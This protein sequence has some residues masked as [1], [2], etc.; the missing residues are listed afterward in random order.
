MKRLIALA[1][2]AG[3]GKNTAADMLGGRQIAFAEPLKRFCQEVFAFTDEQVWGRSE[4]RNAPDKRYPRGDCP[5]CFGT[6]IGGPDQHCRECGGRGLEYLTPR[7]AL[8]TLG[9]EWGRGCFGNVWAELGVRRAL[10]FPEDLVV[11]TDCRFINE[12]KSVRA[13]GGEVWRIVR[14]GAGLDG[15]AGL[16]PS[17]AEQEST[18]FLALVGRT[19]VNSGTLDDLKRI[20]ITDHKDQ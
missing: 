2:R 1:G 6:G 20:L 12:A 4:W 9:T 8:Q 7:Y 17:E 13:A 15:A 18:E 11:I 19:V 5:S 3:S 16:H 10:A 14:Q